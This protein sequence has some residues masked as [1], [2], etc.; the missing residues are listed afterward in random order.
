[1]SKGVE[2]ATAYLKGKTDG[3]GNVHEHLSQVIL[4]L[5]SEG[6]GDALELLEHVSVLVKTGANARDAPEMKPAVAAPAIAAPAAAAAPAETKTDWV[7]STLKLYPG[8]EDED[9]QPEASTE[10]RD[11]LADAPTLAWAGVSLGKETTYN[12]KL[13]MENVAVLNAEDNSIAKLQFWG[14]ILGTKA[15][16]IVLQGELESP[17]EAP[18]TPEGGN[19]TLTPEGAEGANVY[20]YWVANSVEGVFKQLP[21]VT[22]EQIIAAR[23]LKRLFTGNLETVVGGHPPFPGATEAG[24]LRAVIALITAS[25][26]VIPKNLLKADEEDPWTIAENEDEEEF[27][28]ATAAV[29]SKSLSSWQLLTPGLNADGRCRNVPSEDDDADDGPKADATPE[30]P[31]LGKLSANEWGIG[32][33]GERACVR[34]TCWPGAIGIASGSYYLNAYIGYGTCCSTSCQSYCPPFPW[35][36]TDEQSDKD[37]SEAPDVTEAPLPPPS[38]EGDEEEDE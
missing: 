29:L 11:I 1:M 7:A 2:E 33:A 28:P 32:C 17:P 3:S 22:P 6:H 4:K 14:K 35:S 10:I 13:A 5:F 15:D 9:E 37:I 23:T 8:G 31:P 19:A 27:V 25:T 36:I 18:E 16:Y 38:E 12:L 26:H 34:S 30:F 20:T 24:L 21:N